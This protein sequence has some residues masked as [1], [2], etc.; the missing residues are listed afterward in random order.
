[1]K[2]LSASVRSAVVLFPQFF[3]K[4]EGE[5]P[6]PVTAKLQMPLLFQHERPRGLGRACEPLVENHSRRCV[7]TCG[8]R[9]NRTGA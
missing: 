5:K 8:F 2:L 7:G 4:T 6:D 1:M 3:G 9:S